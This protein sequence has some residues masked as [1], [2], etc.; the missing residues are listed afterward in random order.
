[1]RVIDLVDTSVFAALIRVPGRD[2][3]HDEV[4]TEFE[5]RI[6]AGI[7]FVLPVSTIIET[8]NLIA[9]GSGDR[10]SAAKRFLQALTLARASDPPWTIRDVA[11]DSD[12]LDRFVAGD[13][14]GQELLE[15]LTAGTL[16][17]GD[18]AILVERD[19]LSEGLSNTNVRVWT[20]DD[21]LHAHGGGA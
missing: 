2:Q 7:S 6:G 5:Q 10:R 18:V 13:S 17:S 21:N 3:R 14:T 8:G 19:L 9:N 20:H 12:F 11:W 15:H 16:G 4:R 1:M